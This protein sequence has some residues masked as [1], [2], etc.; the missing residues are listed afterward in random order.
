MEDRDPT[1]SKPDLGQELKVAF[2]RAK[3]EHGI[4]RRTLAAAV[5]TRQDAAYQLRKRNAPSHALS[6]L[7]APPRSIHSWE[8][9]FLR[10]F[11]NDDFPVKKDLEDVLDALEEQAPGATASHTRTQWFR[12]WETGPVSTDTKSSRDEDTLAPAT[13]QPASNQA[14]RDVIIHGGQYNASGDQT[15]VNKSK[16]RHRS[17]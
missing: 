2:T 15:I 11:T 5:H 8:N 17:D 1:G 14:G 4:S 7:P 13:P 3:E 9:L 10:W 6:A 16:K 12:I